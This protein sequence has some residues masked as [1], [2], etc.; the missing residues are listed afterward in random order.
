MQPAFDG[1]DRAALLRQIAQEE[2]PPLRRLNPSIPADL[3]TIVGK[4]MAK[5]P[6]DRYATAQALADDLRRFLEDKPI[7]RQAAVAVG[8]GGQMGAAAA[9]PGGG[10]GRAAAVWPCA[11]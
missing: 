2:P 10:G 4:A 8:K 1:R 5:S 9:R 3:E 11:A 7:L 6:G